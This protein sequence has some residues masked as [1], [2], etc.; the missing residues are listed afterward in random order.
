MLGLVL[1]SSYYY[2]CVDRSAFSEVSIF[3]SNLSLMGFA[4]VGFIIGFGTHLA[5]GNCTSVFFCSLPKLSKRFIVESVIVS[6]SAMSVATLQ[7]SVK[8]PGL[9]IDPN[10]ILLAEELNFDAKN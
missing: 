5:G 7:K 2:I 1:A 4:L 3:L 8:L 9:I 10:F 6:L